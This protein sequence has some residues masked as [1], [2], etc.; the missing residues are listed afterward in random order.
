VAWV[1]VGSNSRAGVGSSVGPL[2]GPSV[3]SSV[4]SSAGHFK[5]VG[6]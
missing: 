5:E 2:V 6:L 3:G 4:G 1:A